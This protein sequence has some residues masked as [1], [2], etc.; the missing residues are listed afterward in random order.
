MGRGGRN[1]CERQKLADH[2]LDVESEEKAE[3]TRGPEMS[4]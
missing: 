4:S 3:T 2:R 1:G